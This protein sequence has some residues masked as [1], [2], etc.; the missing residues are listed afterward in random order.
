MALKDRNRFAR[1]HQQGLVIFQILKRFQN[2]IKGFPIAGGLS[3]STVYHQVHGAFSD[4]WI[5]VVL[6]HA[7][8]GFSKP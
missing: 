4:F 7:V 5:Q 1:L 8:S 6:N 2:G 3:T